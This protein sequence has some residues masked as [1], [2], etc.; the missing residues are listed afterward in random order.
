MFSKITLT[1]FLVFFSLLPYTIKA[2]SF[3]R[4][5]HTS[6][7]QTLAGVDIT[8]VPKDGAC[9]YNG[10]NTGP[11]YIGC[12]GISNGYLYKFQSAV[13]PAVNVTNVR[14][15]LTNVNSGEFITF[16]VNGRFFPITQADL[17]L[18]N[19][20][21]ILPVSDAIGGK[22]GAYQSNSAAIVD[23]AS[24]DPIDSV[25]V[26]H[27]NGKFSGTHYTFEFKSDPRVSLVLPLADTILCLGDT[28][29][30]PFFTTTAFNGDNAFN[31]ELSDINGSFDNP[32][33]VGT[34]YSAT[35]SSVMA[36][37]PPST[38]RGNK[39]R[40]RLTSSSPARITEDNGTDLGIYPFPTVNASNNGP[41][42]IG[43]R[44]VLTATADEG[45]KF[46]WQG[47]SGYTST[48]A[49]PSISP[50]TAE[51][52]GVYTVKADLFGCV[53]KDTTK[54]AIKPTPDVSAVTNNGPLCEGRELVISAKTSYANAILTWDG[55]NVQKQDG[56]EIKI[57]SSKA[58]DKGTYKVYSTLNGCKSETLETFANVKPL[59]AVPYVASNSP[60]RVGDEV[61]LTGGSTTEG[62][63]FTW[64]GPDSFIAYMADTSAGVA[65]KRDSNNYT[66]TAT[67][68]SCSTS[69]SL[70]IDVIAEQLQLLY[71]NPTD[72]EMTVKL[73][74]EKNESKK[75]AM[76]I[77]D[78]TG[79]VVQHEEGEAKYGAMIKTVKVREGLMPGV[80]ILRMATGKKTTDIK[81]FYRP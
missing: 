35:T 64:T 32:T 6:G 27:D 11:Y 31:A 29:Q 74:L 60:I 12:S 17:S 51:F 20:T 42:C 71:P 28:I 39:Y 34:T 46:L 78:H 22:V 3:Q 9:V 7:T 14:V 75:I 10:C 67:L 48:E 54:V 79:K 69:N 59:P 52:A 21:C 37:I 5:T 70:F 44:M 26:V 30:V 65:Y 33:V 56:K 55:P 36:V 62:V 61:K 77:I 73:N 2:Q 45:S 66:L 13:I 43:D 81:F 16:Y 47:P 23:I 53:S 24:P 25:Y 4:L 80:Y 41:V 8:V 58:S 49:G 18:Y 72:G 40:I 19:G 76:S 68:D 50:M 57:P 15:H 1:L 63:S 38:P